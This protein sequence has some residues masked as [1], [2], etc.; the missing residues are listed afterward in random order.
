MAKTFKKSESSINAFNKLKESNNKKKKWIWGLS[1]VALLSLISTTEMVFVS[2]NNVSASETLNNDEETINKIE[3]LEKS[4]KE[5][6]ELVTK[7]ESNKLSLEDKISKYNSEK[8]ILNNEISTLRNNIVENQSIIGGLTNQ[9]NS[10]D[11]QITELRVEKQRL[12]NE[13][14]SNNERIEELNILISQLESE[15][16]NL[17]FTISEKETVI[18]G[19]EQDV[20]SYV[21]QIEELQNTIDSLNEGRTT[22]TLSNNEMYVSSLDFNYFRYYRD[23]VISLDSEGNPIDFVVF[24][25]GTTHTEHGMTKTLYYINGTPENGAYAVRTIY[26]KTD[27][28]VKVKNVEQYIREDVGYQINLNDF[29]YEI[30]SIMVGNDA[31]Q[32][33]RVTISDV[34]Q[35]KNVASL[36]ASKPSYKFETE[37]LY[38]VNFNFTIRGSQYSTMENFVMYINTSK[39]PVLNIQDH[40]FSDESYTE[41]IS[42]EINDEQFVMNFKMFDDNET[43]HNLTITKESVLKVM[44]G[45]QSH[46]YNRD[47]NVSENLDVE[48]VHT[49]AQS[50]FTNCLLVNIRDASG[51][52]SG[53]ITLDFNMLLE[54]FNIENKTFITATYESIPTNLPVSVNFNIIDAKTIQLNLYNNGEVISN[55]VIDRDSFDEMPLTAALCSEHD[56]KDNET[57]YLSNTYLI[58]ESENKLIYGGYFYEKNGNESGMTEDEMGKNATDVIL[59][60][61]HL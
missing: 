50:Y 38:A 14:I 55:I 53:Y 25:G 34:T 61:I 60:I 4:N 2:N 16:D 1:T 17:I 22:I 7:L 10:L 47:I 41:L 43:I 24:D 19:L 54:S 13:N 27:N 48:S 36:T 37:S 5:L 6:Q 18:F 11:L 56:T 31:V 46:F 21:T 39:N 8:E 32:N 29:E 59:G 9:V 35:G 33:V 45:E 42:T 23:D 49:N 40:M 58:K 51:N 15:R 30:D 52:N 57:F 28:P 12:E 3:S 20:E 44:N 26:E